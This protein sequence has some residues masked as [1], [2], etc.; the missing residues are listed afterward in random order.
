LEPERAGI[1]LTWSRSVLA[2]VCAQ[3]QILSGPP[4]G[5][6]QVCALKPAMAGSP[7]NTLKWEIGSLQSLSFPWLSRTLARHW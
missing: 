3:K 4:H 6:R 5:S 2:F 7:F 1:L